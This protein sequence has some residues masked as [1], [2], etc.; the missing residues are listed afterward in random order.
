M[1]Q[2]I[3][4]TFTKGTVLLKKYGTLEAALLATFPDEFEEKPSKTPKPLSLISHH[5]P[6]ILLL[7][8]FPFS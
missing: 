6:L 2:I 8:L 1:Y 5:E 3:T 7:F 4:Q